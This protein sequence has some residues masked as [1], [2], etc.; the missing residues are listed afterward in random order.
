MVYWTLNDS[1]KMIDNGSVCSM[2]VMWQTWV[3]L[4]DLLSLAHDELKEKSA[5]H[6][7][8][9]TVFIS[10]LHVDGGFSTSNLHKLMQESYTF[11]IILS[12]ISMIYKAITLFATCSCVIISSSIQILH[13]G[14][15]SYI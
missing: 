3:E 5:R 15:Q 13:N 7:L 1:L 12:L 4:G 11:I 14:E 2:I 6:C 8:N 9:S 10:S